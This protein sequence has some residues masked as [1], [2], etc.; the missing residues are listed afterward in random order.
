MRH[1]LGVRASFL[2]AGP[3]LAKA[4][5]HM[6]TKNNPISESPSERDPFHALC[7]LASRE[8]WCWDLSCSTCGQVEFRY[9]LR[10]LIAGKHPDAPEWMVSKSKQ[11]Y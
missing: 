4:G 3:W 10:E 2:L 11:P 8:S 5:T 1:E 7:L 9:A 6:A